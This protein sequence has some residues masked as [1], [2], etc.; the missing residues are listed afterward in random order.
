MDLPINHVV[1]ANAGY[2]GVVQ[3]NNT[4][5]GSSGSGSLLAGT[6][7]ILTAAHVV[8]YTNSSAAYSASGFTVYFDTTGGRITVA[9]TAIYVNSAWDGNADDGNDVAL[10]KIASVPNGVTGFSLY[11]GT[12]E[13]GQTYNGYGYGMIGTG[14]TGEQPNTDDTMHHWENTFDCTGTTIGLQSSQLVYDFDDGTAAHD[15]LGVEYGI[16]NLGLGVN[17]GNSAK[18]DSGGPEFIDGKIAAIVSFGLEA[19]TDIDGSVNSTYG[20][21]SVDTRMSSFVPWVASVIANST[22]EYLVNSNDIY[23]VANGTAYDIRQAIEQPEPL[24]GGDGRRRRL[25]HRL[26]QL[27]TDG[28]SGKYGAGYNG[29]NGVFAKRYSSDGLAT[30]FSFQVNQT[31]TGN[32]Q[33]ASVAMD[34]DGDFIVS[35]ESNTNGSTYDIYA[36]RYV[37]TATAEYSLRPTSSI[38]ANYPTSSI[39]SPRIRSTALNGEIGGE[40]PGQ[41]DDRRQSAVRQRRDGRHRR[42]RGR[43]DQQRRRVLSAL[44]PNDRHCRTD[45]GRRVRR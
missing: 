42:R 27:R 10:I 34:A 11:T 14:I 33:D 31:T 2:S 43:L 21:I 40:V 41:L 5:D 4:F 18:G 3:V 30:S 37:S 44:R 7:F 45:R 17:E 36:R 12:N 35:W 1:S 19:S 38:T 15:A 13:V 26:D 22:T 16:H 39:R 8:C 25:H 20:E 32:Q 9:A 24:F 29:E 23:A 28:G 6:D